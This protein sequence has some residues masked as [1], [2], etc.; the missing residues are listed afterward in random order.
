[1]VQ[2]ILVREANKSDV[3]VLVSYN[4]AMA[5]ETE[6]VALNEGILR[7]GIEKTLELKDCH[8]FVAELDGKVV[9]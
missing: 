5:S 7:L 9:G 2:D 4:R 8:Y 3:S 6:N 1:M